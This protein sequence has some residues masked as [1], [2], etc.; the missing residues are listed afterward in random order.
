M[1]TTAW[2]CTCPTSAI[3]HD[4]K[5][6]PK[7]GQA[8]TR[9]T[10]PVLCAQAA[11]RAAVVSGSGWRSSLGIWLRCVALAVAGSWNGS[12]NGS[13]DDPS[14]VS[15]ISAIFRVI[16]AASAHRAW[17]RSSHNPSAVGSSPTRPT[18]GF[19]NRL[20]HERAGRALWS[21]GRQ[22]APR[23]RSVTSGHIVIGSNNYRSLDSVGLTALLRAPLS[24]RRPSNSVRRGV[25]GR[26]A[27]TGQVSAGPARRL[28]TVA[29]STSA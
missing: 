14:A 26:S 16:G 1:R 23:S 13:Q 20:R 6:W 10:G 4:R 18:C 3:R 8:I 2:S 5:S 29:G 15:A 9:Q 19:N 11:G 25:S 7:P 22:R 17:G 21:G 27:F 24:G 12:W 28:R